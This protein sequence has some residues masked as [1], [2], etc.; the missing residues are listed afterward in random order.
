MS[1]LPG[2]EELGS[3]YDCLNG[4]Y[5]QSESCFKVTF[6]P[7]V[8]VYPKIAVE[9]FSIAGESLDE[10]HQ[11]ISSS[12]NIGGGFLGFT[13]SLETEFGK[14]VDYSTFQK[15]SRIQYNYYTF[16][17]LHLTSS[18]WYCGNVLDL[19]FELKS[20]IQK[21]NRRQFFNDT[22]LILFIVTR[23]GRIVLSICTNKL[24]YNS[25]TD[26]KTVAKAA[27]QEIFH[28]NISDEYKEE[29][30]KLRENN[31]INLIGCG[32][33]ISALRNDMMHQNVNAW[34][35]TVPDSPFFITFDK[36]DRC[37]LVVSLIFIKPKILIPIFYSNLHSLSF[38]GDLVDEIQ[39][40]YPPYLEYS[41]VSLTSTTA[42]IGSKPV[43]SEGSK[44]KWLAVS[45]R[46]ETLLKHGIVI[47]EKPYAQGLLRPIVKKNYVTSF[48]FGDHS[49]LV[50]L[51]QPLTDDPDNF[52]SLGCFLEQ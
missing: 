21:S 30:K 16:H 52:V 7:F 23:W 47:R 37:L 18:P 43:I 6:L 3:G 14:V 31:E 4:Q 19:K 5:A 36:S 33:D 17:L 28:G 12:L 26:L 2:L 49:Y 29:V 46:L 1:L 40:F 15:F 27:A 38:I 25:S 24:I 22:E 45:Y 42:R 11:S 41:I 44:W 34:I 9:Y 13:S 39:A 8:S 51:Y 32:G 48:Y 50:R 35:T 20:M 10:Y